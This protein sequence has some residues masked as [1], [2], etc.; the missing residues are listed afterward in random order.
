MKPALALVATLALGTTAQQLTDAQIR[1]VRSRLSDVAKQSWELGTR[2]QVLIEY[3]APAFNVLSTDCKLPPNTTLSQSQSSALSTPFGIVRPIVTSGGSVSNTQGNNAGGDGAAAS[4]SLMDDGSAADPA[5]LGVTVALANWTKAD[6]G[7]V[8]YGDAARDEL[9]F[10]LTKAPR[11]SEGAISHR[12]EKVQLW[13]DFVYMVPPFLAYYGA[14]HSNTTIMDEAF[15]QI[16]LYRDQLHDGESNNLW[17]HIVL[18]GSG[19]DGG[20]WSTGN[21]WAAMGMLRVLGTYKASSDLGSTY[22]Q[23]I[24][25]LSDWVQEILDGMY[26][27]VENSNTALFTNYADRPSTFRDAS[28]TALIAAATYRLAVLT[29]GKYVSRIPDAER[30]RRELSK[31]A[32]DAGGHIDGSGWLSPVVDPHNF[33]QQGEHSPEG[34]AFVISMIAAYRDWNGAGQPGVNAA[35]SRATAS[36]GLALL[37]GLV[38]AL[39][40]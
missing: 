28:S 29:D 36:V 6:D 19:E 13:S 33:G 11:S 30:A 7:G 14:L 9:N 31:Y 38:S 40:L 37:V 25:T 17:K 22:G 24:S 1:A 39:M 34:Q 32:G 35:T 21:G 12:T 18:G 15:N 26:A 4:G 5:S 3:D 27:T 16:R 8:R 10:L 20:R 2:A 23:S